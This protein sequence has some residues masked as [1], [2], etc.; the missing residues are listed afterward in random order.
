MKIRTTFKW[1][2]ATSSRLS[3]HAKETCYKPL[4]AKCHIGWDSSSK[5][6]M[7]LS[8]IAMKAKVEKMSAFVMYHMTSSRKSSSKPYLHGGNPWEATLIRNERFNI[9]KID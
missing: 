7:A 6:D 3:A 5:D 8:K 1:K 9:E 2:V 4:G